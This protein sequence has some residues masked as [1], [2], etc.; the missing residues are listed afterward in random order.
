MASFSSRIYYRN[1]FLH[2]G[3][4]QT[5]CYNNDFAGEKGGTCYAIVDDRQNPMRSLQIQEDLDFLGTKSIKVISVT[6]HNEPIHLYTKELAKEGLIYIPGTYDAVELLNYPK[7]N[8]QLKLRHGDHPTIGYSKQTETGGDYVIIYIFDYIIKVLDD[9]LNVT[10]VVTTTSNDVA[11][12]DI[13]NFFTER[14][15]LTYHSLETYKIGGFRYSKKDWPALPEDDPRLMT[16]RGLKSRHVP[17]EVIYNFYKH[18]TSSQGI[19]ITYFDTLLKNYMGLT[20][21]HVFGVIDP[22]VVRVTNLEDRYTEFVFKPFHPMKPGMFNISP[23]SNTIYID[24]SDFSLV[25]YGDKLSKDR[26]IRLKYAN[27]LYCTGVTL[28]EGGTVLSLNGKYYNKDIIPTKQPIHWVSSEAG[29]KPRNA[30]FYL[31]NW[32]FTGDNMSNIQDPVVKD[33]YIDECVFDDL[34]QIY[35]LERVGYFVYDNELTLKN[36]GVPCFIKICNIAR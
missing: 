21:K 24:R 3:H 11:D 6:E 23:L 30:R 12:V 29:K 1:T 14:H 2:V 28:G 34:D 10:D 25:E 26:E 5:L 36:G 22:I 32:F 20:A 31:Y 18:A 9:L 15:P 27:V 4:L 7:G 19:K 16:L 35:Q 8:F 13:M 17:A 33:G